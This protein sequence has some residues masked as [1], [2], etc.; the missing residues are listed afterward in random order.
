MGG[1][2]QEISQGIYSPR[3]PENLAATPTASDKPVRLP[4]LSQLVP[5]L[6]LIECARLEG[7][8]QRQQTVALENRLA[9][10]LQTFVDRYTHDHSITLD[11]IENHGALLRS[12]F[13][14]Q[15]RSLCGRQDSLQSTLERRIGDLERQFAQ[16]RQRENQIVGA[17]QSMQSRIQVLT[18]LLRELHS[19]N[20]RLLE[21]KST[22]ETLSP[23]MDGD[24]FAT[25]VRIEVQN[26]IQSLGRSVFPGRVAAH[27][28]LARSAL[29]ISNQIGKEFLQLEAARGDA[30]ASNKTDDEAHKDEPNLD[31]NLGPAKTAA[32]TF[33]CHW[34]FS[35]RMGTLIVTIRST[36]PVGREFGQ[37]ITVIKAIFRPA[38]WL[39]LLGIE[40]SLKLEAS[41]R[42]F[43][44]IQP[45][46]TWFSILPDQSPVFESAR[47]G[48]LGHLQYL[49][50]H[51][52][53]SV[54]DQDTKGW[55]PLHVSSPAYITVY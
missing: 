46:I 35:G 9:Q 49:F 53:A 5:G 27:E 22:V 55:T 17:I 10:S 18:N 50:T 45:G 15:L 36:R 47:L 40:T 16:G 23:A 51:G 28:S 25:I 44:K 37:R 30:S 39:P 20:S 43:N 41:H 52:L 31:S 24:P 3:H 26:V 42:G 19:L 12:S 21:R 1:E 33:R 4:P 38:A 29:E 32:Q 8:D 14:D 54:F 48:D 34:E 7:I 11:S 13:D 2:I 6:M